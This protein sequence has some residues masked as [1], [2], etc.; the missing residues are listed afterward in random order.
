MVVKE[1]GVLKFI[2]AT[3]DGV[4]C[5]SVDKSLPS[6]LQ[7]CREMA[8]RRLRT[9]RTPEMQKAC[10]EFVRASLGKSYNFNVLQMM[11]ASKSDDSHNDKFFCSQLVAKAYQ[12]MGLLSKHVPSSNYMPANLASEELQLLEG[13]LDPMS[14]YC[15]LSVDDEDVVHIEK[16][17]NFLNERRKQAE[18][19]VN[20]T[21]RSPM[22]SSF[23]PLTFVPFVQTSLNGKSNVSVSSARKPHKRT[24]S[25]T[26]FLSAPPSTFIENYNG[27]TKSSSN[28]VHTKHGNN[29]DQDYE[30]DSS[31]QENAEVFPEE[32]VVKKSFIGE[33]EEESFPPKQ[34][35]ESTNIERVDQARNEKLSTSP[36]IK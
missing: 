24:G 13:K 9:V 25:R 15:S 12:L 26:Y 8:V 11:G 18:K 6:Y 5:Y 35:S 21:E 17:S 10:E 30:D 4:S 19:V 16:E 22:V 3:S 31:D 20:L 36:E 33:I 34:E 7:S 32:V 2:E 27:H 14:T 1:K 29:E 28:G 23:V